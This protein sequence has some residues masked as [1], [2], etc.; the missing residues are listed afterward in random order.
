MGMG[1]TGLSGKDLGGY[2]ERGWWTLAPQLW[3]RL[4]PHSVCKKSPNLLAAL[5]PLPDLNLKK[6][7]RWVWCWKGQVPQGIRSKKECIKSCETYFANTLTLNI[8]V[9]AWVIFP[10]AIWPWLTIIPHSSLNVIYC[11]I[12]TAWQWL[13]GL[14][15]ECGS[16]SHWLLTDYNNALCTLTHLQIIF[17]GTCE[18]PAS[19]KLCGIYSG[20]N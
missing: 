1:I 14:I 8:R 4:S 11:L 6:C 3:H 17:P 15:W 16:W 9:Q 19:S 12:I 18:R 20:P 10:L 5:L 7:L 2:G 13:M